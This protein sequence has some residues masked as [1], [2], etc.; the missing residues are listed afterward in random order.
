M[1]ILLSLHEEISFSFAVTSKTS[2]LIKQH[3]KLTTCKFS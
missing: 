2:F 1:L 3:Y